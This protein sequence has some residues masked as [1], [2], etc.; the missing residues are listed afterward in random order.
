M[1]SDIADAEAALEDQR[2]GLQDLQ[3]ALAGMHEVPMEPSDLA[4]AQYA[5][6]VDCLSILLG[7]ADPLTLSAETV[8]AQPGL[9]RAS[10]AALDELYHQ[11]V[12]R[13]EN[14]LLEKAMM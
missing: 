1:Q 2:Q 11:T 5:Q 14:A 10:D 12:D 8:E 13:L 6:S 9:G 4:A 3:S 7:T